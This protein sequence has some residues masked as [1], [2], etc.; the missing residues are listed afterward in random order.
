M[1]SKSPSE[2]WKKMTNALSGKLTVKSIN[3]I[4]YD[5]HQIGPHK[6][7]YR[8][9]SRSAGEIESIKNEE[10]EILIGKLLAVD[11]FNTNTSKQ[12][13]RDSKIYRQRSP[14]FAILLA[15]EVIEK[16]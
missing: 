10:F 13:F 12:A 11:I 3:G 9:E 1:K 8:A 16:L 15:S 5:L 4:V 14:V 7:E 6:I 2:L